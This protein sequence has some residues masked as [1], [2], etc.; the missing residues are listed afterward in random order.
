MKKMAF[1]RFRVLVMALAVAAFL[2][3]SVAYAAN[4][5]AKKRYSVSMEDQKGHQGVEVVCAVNPK[6]AKEKALAKW[7]HRGHHRRVTGVNEQ[8]QCEGD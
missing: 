8:G 7:G 3:G 4:G 6:L 1:T 5:P 2:A